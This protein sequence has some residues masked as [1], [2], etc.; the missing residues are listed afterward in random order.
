[1]DTT[2]IYKIIV[3]DHGVSFHCLTENCDT[4][5]TTLSKF[6]IFLNVSGRECFDQFLLA[7]NIYCQVCAFFS[8]MT[9]RVVILSD[10]LSEPFSFP[11]EFLLFLQSKCTW[12]KFQITSTCLHIRM[13]S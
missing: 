9:L 8:L 10:N 12:S 11:K 4:F 6:S 7:I 2:G 5:K 3:S 1:M 13:V